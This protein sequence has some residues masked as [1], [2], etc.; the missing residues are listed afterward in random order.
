MPVISP[1][2]RVFTTAK[3]FRPLVY[4]VSD[5]PGAGSSV[6]VLNTRKALTATMT[7]NHLSYFTAVGSFYDVEQ[8]NPSG[9]TNIPM[10]DQVSGYVDF[11]PGTQSS[12]FP[13]GFAAY[14]PNLDHG[15]GTYGNTLVPLAPITG[16]MMNGQLC[17]I[18]MGDPVGVE[19]VTDSWLLGLSSTLYYHVRFRNVTYGGALQA[20]SNFAFPAPSN[21]ST[22]DITSPSLVRTTYVG[23]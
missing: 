6:A 2:R 11:F 4:P 21:S 16:R 7:L 19:L 13:V 3:V 9:S 10:M 17:T 1:H 20:L 22:L 14:V 15:D 23:P 18:A 5:T 12:V 8:P